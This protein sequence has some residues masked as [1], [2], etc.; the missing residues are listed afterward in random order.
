MLHIILQIGIS[1]I[2]LIYYSFHKQWSVGQIV[3]PFTAL[4]SS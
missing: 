2:V 4:S 3:L 1:Y